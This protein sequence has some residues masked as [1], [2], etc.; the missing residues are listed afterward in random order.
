MILLKEWYDPQ[1]KWTPAQYGGVKIMRIPS[2]DLWLPDIILLNKYGNLFS[3][4]TCKG[5]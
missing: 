5:S 3:L 4:F 1:L 2:A